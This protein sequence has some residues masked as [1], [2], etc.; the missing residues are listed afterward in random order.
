[1]AEE[2]RRETA[3]PASLY[4]WTRRWRRTRGAEGH[5]D[6]CV[7]LLELLPSPTIPF[8][9][10]FDNFPPVS[11]SA[12]LPGRSREAPA[13]L[14][15]PNSTSSGMN[16]FAPGQTEIPTNIDDH[17]EIQSK[18]Y[19][20]K[21]RWDVSRVTRSGGLKSE[22]VI[23]KKVYPKSE[24]EFFEKEAERVDMLLIERK[25]K[26]WMFLSSKEKP[27]NWTSFSISFVFFIVYLILET[28][29][30]RDKR[31]V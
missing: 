18:K 3:V 4:F 31:T 22:Y 19:S 23:G 9:S 6:W 12:L 10:F 26:N 11:R 30:S 28:S 15:L 13:L 21:N 27:R 2:G 17:W 8:L 14:W 29:S 24:L 16:Y 7:L 5:Q 20:F 1:M 25:L